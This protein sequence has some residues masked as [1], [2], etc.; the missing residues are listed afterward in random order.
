MLLGTPAYM[1]PE[2]AMG[3][4]EVDPRG[5]IYSLGAVALFMLTGRPPFQGKSLGEV[6]AAHRF[7]RPPDLSDQQ[8][9]IPPDLA[10][11]VARC[12]AKERGERFPTVMDLDRELGKCSCSSDWSTE[13]AACWWA[14][15]TL[16][17]SPA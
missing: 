8:G 13:R 7:D 1:S 16:K 6:L 5:D 2:Q 17:D 9:R 11:V 4:T 15:R 14:E 12:L 10:A 3:N